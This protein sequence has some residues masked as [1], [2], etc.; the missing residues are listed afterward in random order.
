LLPEGEEPAPSRPPRPFDP[1]AL[2]A[3]LDRDNFDVRR[4]TLEL[5]S[6]PAFAY[7]DGSDTAAYR[8]RVMEWCHRLAR[9]RLTAIAYPARFGGEN[10]VARSIAV[11]ETLAYHDLSMLVKFGVQFGLFSGS[12]YQLG[13]H[14]H[15]E[16]FLRSAATLELPGCFAMTETG[17]GSNV[18][19]LETTAAYDAGSR[20]FIIRTPSASARKDYIGNA[21]LH[22]RMA[23]VFAQLHAQG[24]VHGVHAFLV[25]IRDDHNRPMP[26]VR[27][28]E[29]GHKEGLNG[30]DNGRLSF[31]DVR[32]PRENLL[33]RFGDVAEDG[34]YSSPIA[35]PARRFFTMLGTLVAG[36]ISIAA[37]AMNASKS[38]LTI[39]IRYAERRRQ[40][41]PEGQ[42]EIP[43]LDYL[44]LQRR[45]FSRLATTYALDFALKD[46]IRRFAAG[47]GADTREIEAHAAGLKA[48]SARHTV[49]TLQ[50]CRQAT[51]AQGYMSVNR[52]SILKADTD[53][54][55][56]FEGAN[57]VLLQLLARG[58]LTEY[59]EEF[60]EL[61]LWGVLKYMA[62]RA[63]TVI[64]E[65]NPIATRRTDQE[66]LRDPAFLESAL[67]YREDRL[68][69][70]LGRRLR[71]RIQ[72]GQDSFAALNACQDHAIAL[73]EAHVERVI[74]ERFDEGID[75]CPEP[76]L[77]TALAR[78]AALFGLWTIE[79]DRG[80]FLE[81]GYL[82]ATKARAIRDQ[83]NVLCGEIRPYA[84]ALVDG[85]GIPD[86]LLAAPIAIAR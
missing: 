2:H 85:F 46:L 54:F 22:G 52:L 66:H 48:F 79:Q 14:T 56:T 50:A 31:A 82:E 44:V 32:I 27:I 26:G 30:V 83:V 81:T 51:G 4:R 5:L 60:G 77:A 7:V 72:D 20:E 45:L 68:L 40:F 19:D 42:S 29:C 8:E 55:T 76:G 67:R 65:L 38:G 57:S 41:G 13:T 61:R 71:R 34:T 12:I 35:S 64:T 6:T 69:D 24:D 39:A 1:A 36:R 75:Q 23:T 58:L 16:R 33:N 59:R 17:H 37:A 3:F 18:R 74:L 73:A 49:E 15:H 86:A 25:P 11:F 9:E 10:D 28:E 78:L 43:I 53:I 84:V 21:A 47:S 63:A 80:W 62:G 70:S